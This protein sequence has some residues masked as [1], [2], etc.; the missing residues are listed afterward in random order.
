[1]DPDPAGTFS[2]VL[3]HLQSI[4]LNI[5]YVILEAALKFISLTDANLFILFEAKGARF[6]GGKD[7]LCADFRNGALNFD[8]GDIELET[9]ADSFSLRTKTVD[10]DS[11]DNSAFQRAEQIDNETF[12]EELF[13]TT[14]NE[15]ETFAEGLFCTT[16][17]DNE[18]FAQG[19]F[20][21]TDKDNETYAEGLSCTTS[22][23]ETPASPS[24]SDVKRRKRRKRRKQKDENDDDDDEDVGK[25]RKFQYEETNCVKQEVVEEAVETHA[26]DM[27]SQH[28]E[29]T[30][31]NNDYDPS[32]LPDAA[33][34][35]DA[36]QPL[37]EDQRRISDWF[38]NVFRRDRRMIAR[39]IKIRKINGSGI[40]TMSRLDIRTDIMAFFYEYGKCF[41]EE[42]FDKELPEECRGYAFQLPWLHFANF[43]PH[44][45]VKIPKKSFYTTCQDSF[46]RPYRLK[47][48]LTSRTTPS[49]TIDD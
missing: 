44:K 23:F 5:A 30:T 34:V 49:T 3:D 8:S 10:A 9:A 7:R 11:S 40:K 38:F 28:Q 43:H 31:S 39:M 33:E 16:D 45:D 24:A 37:D 25:R 47:R 15:N 1:M 13:C 46:A 21:T 6:F 2:S 36:Y 27:Y 4:D 17:K 26:I 35:N 42:F 14:D 41:T 32:L 29:A 19:L 22:D 12:A 18:T 20:C 48:Q